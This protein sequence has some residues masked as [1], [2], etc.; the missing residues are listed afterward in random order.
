MAKSPPDFNASASGTGYLYQIRCALLWL[1]DADDDAAVSLEKSDDVTFEKDG[2]PEE[3]LQTKHHIDRTA[4]LTDASADLWKTIRVWSEDVFHGRLT[5]TTRLA[6][7]T[8]GVAPSGSIAAMLKSKSEY[9][10]EPTALAR[11]NDVST[12]SENESLKS[13]FSAFNLLTDD[14][15]KNLVSRIR[16]LDAVQD[17]QGVGHEVCSRL[18]V[19][20]DQNK[21]A[22]FNNA[23]EGWWFKRIVVQW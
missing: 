3:K 11:L 16:V 21:R 17:I 19:A 20:A 4:S 8:T 13:A 6:L 23:A 2:S 22:I 14:L 15:K 5:A 1:L 7:V 9:R 12:K 18:R 10:D